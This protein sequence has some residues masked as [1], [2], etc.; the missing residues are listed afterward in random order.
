MK[1]CHVRRN[2]G[3]KTGAICETGGRGMARVA[4]ELHDDVQ[5]SR[6]LLVGLLARSIDSALRFPVLVYFYPPIST[7]TLS[8][9]VSSVI[10]MMHE[11]D[12]RLVRCQKLN[13]SRRFSLVPLI[14]EGRARAP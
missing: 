4:I 8:P 11:A 13:G 3:G 7:A 1:G 12:E 10:F 2:D 14:A 6:V 5:D 9:R